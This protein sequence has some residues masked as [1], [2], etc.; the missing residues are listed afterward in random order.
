M[1]K[2]TRLR[3]TS[4]LPR[5]RPQRSGRLFDGH[6]RHQ[7]PV[8]TRVDAPNRRHE[9][10]RN[11]QPHNHGRQQQAG[12]RVSGVVRCR[13]ADPRAEA[14]EDDARDG[15]AKVALDIIAVVPARGASVGGQV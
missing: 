5:C 14:A 10:R 15:H 11:C 7:L 3:W 13:D 12:C 1:L 9:R 6:Q 4:T 2:R 8:L